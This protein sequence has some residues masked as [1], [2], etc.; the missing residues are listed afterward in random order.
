MA[1]FPI[2][3][4]KWGVIA[5]NTSTTVR[6]RAVANPMNKTGIQLSFDATF[7]PVSLMAE[8]VFSFLKRKFASGEPLLAGLE[9]RP[10]RYF[11]WERDKNFSGAIPLKMP[12]VF[13][14]GMTI[15]RLL[16]GFLR[17]YRHCPMHWWHYLL[18]NGFS[19][20]PESHLASSCSQSGYWPLPMSL[21][22]VNHGQWPWSN[23]GH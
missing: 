3:G 8:W 14:E 17:S 1:G 23:H 9:C 6:K 5:H 12:R 13:C 22:M 2:F 15:L 4:I 19:W 11:S 7:I 10:R 18:L 21:I 20:G 16:L